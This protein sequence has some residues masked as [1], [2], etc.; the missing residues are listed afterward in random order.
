MLSHVCTVSG[1]ILGERFDKGHKLSFE[2]LGG[3]KP[4]NVGM[5]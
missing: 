1:N 5:I 4:V 2:N 3:L